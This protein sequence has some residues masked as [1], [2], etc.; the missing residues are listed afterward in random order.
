MSLTERWFDIA[1]PEGSINTFT[2]R[3]DKGGPLPTVLFYMD[4]FGLRDEIFDM[5]RRLA[6]AGYFVVA[7]NLYYRRTPHFSS[8]GSPAGMARLFDMMG[9][10]T[11]AGVTADTGAL[12]AWLPSQPAAIATRV[13]AVGYCMS[14]PFVI[15]AAA[16]FAERVACIASIHGARLVTDQA[17]SPHLLARTLR[18][19]VYVGCATHDKWAQPAEMAQLEAGLKHSGAPYLVEWYEGTQHGFVFPQ[20]TGIYDAPA[21]ERHWSRLHALFAR[22]LRG[23]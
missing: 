20:R 10:L 5:V 8:D 1:T 12:L 19:E 3:P 21:A 11:N 23:G 17:D 4:A 7:P 14:G 6:C 16:A 9:H 22:Q 13:G 15:A 18:C 2:A